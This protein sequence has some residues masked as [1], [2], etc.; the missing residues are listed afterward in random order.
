MFEVAHMYSI[1]EWYAVIMD[2][3]GMQMGGWEVGHL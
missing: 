3:K 2:E 1:Q